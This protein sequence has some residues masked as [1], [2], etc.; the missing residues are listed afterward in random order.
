MLVQIYLVMP[1]SLR[2]RNQ[3]FV[4]AIAATGMLGVAIGY[5]LSGYAKLETFKLLNI[6]GL[7]YDLLGILVLS[8][9]VSR[10]TALKRFFVDWVSGS[11]IWAH[12]VVPL[13]AILGTAF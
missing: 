12:T 4:S 5:V 1:L 2:T 9:I 10:N 6:V 3:I 13:G 7:F 8:E 11:L